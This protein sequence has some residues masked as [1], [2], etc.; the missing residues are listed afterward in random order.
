M[1]TVELKLPEDLLAI[2][3]QKVHVEKEYDSVQELVVTALRIL[4]EIKDNNT[5]D[6]TDGESEVIRQRLKDI[7]YM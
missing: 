4:L 2:I 3:K 6:I 5:S 1:E 7:G